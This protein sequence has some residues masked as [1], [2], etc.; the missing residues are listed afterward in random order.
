MTSVPPTSVFGNAGPDEVADTPFPHLVRVNVFPTEQYEEFASTFPSVATILRERTDTQGNAAA[1]LPSRMVLDNPAISPSWRAFFAYHTSTA[2]W[3]DIVR[4]FGTRLR[5]AFPGLEDKVGRPMSEWRVVPRGSRQ[6]YDVKLDCQFVVNTPGQALSSVK[7]AHV[8][9][10]STIFSGLFY[11]R[12]P[13]DDTKGGDLDLYRWTRTPRFF[14]PRMALP[15][16]VSWEKTVSYAANTFACFINN[17]AAVHGVSPRAPSKIER[18]YIN[19]IA[20]VPFDACELPNFGTLAHLR[21][22]PAMRR[23]G[24]RSVGNDKY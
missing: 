4:V 21:H 24:L 14:G 15:T 18:R 6:N 2:F 13:G 20:K 17:A 22:W 12:V 8:D 1:R 23:L 3:N 10:A 16:D 19:L 5:Q 11:M 7:T 9:Q